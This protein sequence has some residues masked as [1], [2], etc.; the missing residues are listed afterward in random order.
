MGIVTTVLS[1]IVFL[2]T[3]VAAACIVGGIGG[4]LVLIGIEWT[5]NR[6]A[7]FQDWVDSRW[8]V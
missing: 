4:I 8:E 5:A 1:A 3:F 7:D 6:I 2:I